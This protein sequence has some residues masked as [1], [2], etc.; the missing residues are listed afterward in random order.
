MGPL[1]GRPPAAA[2]CAVVFAVVLA[3]CDQNVSVTGAVRDPG[4]RALEDVVVT[5]ETPGRTPDVAHTAKDGS[6]NVGIVGADPRRTHL[7]F[8]KEGYVAQARD[9]DGDARPTLAIVLAP[10]A[11]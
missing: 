6:F 10:Q 5:L 8:R 9:L 2:L 11:P 7:S 1:A 4:G 3:G